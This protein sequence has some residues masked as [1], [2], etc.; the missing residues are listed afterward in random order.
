MKR[1]F[2]FGIIALSLLFAH[3]THAVAN[4]SEKIKAHM[5]EN[6]LLW[7]IAV[8]L[9]DADRVISFESPDF[10]RVLKDGT[11]TNK[12]TADAATRLWLGRIRKVYDA[13]VYIKKITILPSKVVIWSV[14]ELDADMNSGTDPNEPQIQHIRFGGTTRDTW[15]KYRDQWYLKRVENLT[16]K[17]EIDG[18]PA[19]GN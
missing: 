5:V 4:E 9:G 13:K 11:V 14:K 15:V 3:A 10:T 12:A 7:Q 6:Y 8:K 17:A 19:E 2:T 18:T 16:F 1:I